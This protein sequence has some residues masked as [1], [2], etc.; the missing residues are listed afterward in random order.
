MAE[1]RFDDFKMKGISEE[2]EETSFKNDDELGCHDNS[3]NI[4]NKSNLKIKYNRVD[5]RDRK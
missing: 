4:I 3:I 1:G 5:Y 2:K